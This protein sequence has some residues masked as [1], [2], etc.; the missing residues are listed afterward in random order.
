M[1]SLLFTEYVYVHEMLSVLSLGKV[2]E[3]MPYTVSENVK[4][5]LKFPVI[6]NLHEVNYPGVLHLGNSTFPSVCVLL[7][8]ESSNECKHIVV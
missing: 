2:K 7:D 6:E 1:L 8:H 4:E 3:I 5:I